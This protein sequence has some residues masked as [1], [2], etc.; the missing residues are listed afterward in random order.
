MSALSHFLYDLLVTDSPALVLSS[1]AEDTVKRFQNRSK[2]K[3]AIPFAV[4]IENEHE[5]R[6]QQLYSDAKIV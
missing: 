1:A 5:K 2:T 6:P 3:F 4:K